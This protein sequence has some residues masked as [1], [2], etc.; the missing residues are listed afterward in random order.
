MGEKTLLLTILR[1]GYV[2]NYNDSAWDNPGSLPIPHLLPFEIWGASNSSFSL[3]SYLNTLIC[4]NPRDFNII[5]QT[6]SSGV[7]DNCI[8]ESVP[9]AFLMRGWTEFYWARTLAEEPGPKD[10]ENG[11]MDALCQQKTGILMAP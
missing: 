5:W 6:V 7:L 10:N 8:S 9:C 2:S 11:W 3:I 4:M 1:L